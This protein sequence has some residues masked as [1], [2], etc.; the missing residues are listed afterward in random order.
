M[1]QADDDAFDIG[2]DQVAGGFANAILAQR[3]H[4]LA[5]HVEA[6]DH[7]ASK[8]ARHQ[9][10]IVA[11]G[12]E[13]NAV[14]IRIAEIGLD[15][16]AH[17]VEVFHAAIDDEAASQPLALNHAVQHRRSGIDAGL[18]LLKGCAEREAPTAEAVLAGRDQA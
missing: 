6:L 14:L 8:L 12:V 5:R 7:T 16:P 13:V 11:M 18:E 15:G 17:A 2:R 9:R 3:D 4:H 10:R 1:E